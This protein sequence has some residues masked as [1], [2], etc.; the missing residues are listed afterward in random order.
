MRAGAI[1][2]G[3]SFIDESKIDA[4]PSLPEGLR[5]ITAPFFLGTKMEAFKGTGPHGLSGQP[6]P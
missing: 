6:R 5:V 3:W 1:S 2:S 4:T